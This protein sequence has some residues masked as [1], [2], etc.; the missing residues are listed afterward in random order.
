M[1]N[2]IEKLTPIFNKVAEKI[3][4]GAEWGWTIL[5]KQQYVVAIQDIIIA[6]G[7]LIATP[8]LYRAI[9]KFTILHRDHRYDGWDAARFFTTLALIGCFVGSVA[10]IYGSVGRFINPEYYAL[11]DIA[12]FVQ[13][14]KE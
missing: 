3:G 6:V 9:K 5:M 1:D 4:Q 8:F 13:G 12:S 2:I 11:K 10:C 14:N 7:L